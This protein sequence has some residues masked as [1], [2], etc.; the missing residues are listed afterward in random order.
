MEMRTR[1]V[2]MKLRE[3]F[4]HHD[5][6]FRGRRYPVLTGPPCAIEAL[7][8]AAVAGQ[9]CVINAE[10]HVKSQDFEA[11]MTA[12]SS[13]PNRTVLTLFA[14][15]NLPTGTRPKRL[16]RLFVVETPEDVNRILDTPYRF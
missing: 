10:N 2:L 15:S 4:Y 3:R 9:G 8:Y 5:N 13:F 1:S 12:A 6:C 7:A 16:G 11:A 14:R